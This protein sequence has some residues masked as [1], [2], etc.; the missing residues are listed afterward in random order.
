MVSF[1]FGGRAV[2]LD[3]NVRRVLARIDLGRQ[4][5]ADATTAAERGLGAQ[6]LPESAELASRWAASSMELG[7]LVCTAA[8]PDCAGCP[9]ADHCRWL[10]AG[11]PAH[12]GPQRRRQAYA[13]TDRQARGALLEV[14]RRSPDGVR[15]EV[16]L[17]A[18]QVDP[19]QARRALAGLAA[20]GLVILEAGTARL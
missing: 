12:D 9:V 20:D 16:L 3:T 14:L 17:E 18:W 4:Y 15:V 7:A 5:P 19:A 10:A 13:G 8:S 6:W 11:L 1:A 2:V